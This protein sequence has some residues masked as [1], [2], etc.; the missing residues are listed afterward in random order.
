MT[1]AILNLNRDNLIQRFHRM[2]FGTTGTYEA[3]TGTQQEET[4]YLEMLPKQREEEQRRASPPSCPPS[5][6]G[7]PLAKASWKA[8]V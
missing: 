2:E 5:P 1:A 8:E 3:G 6:A 7:F 4:Q